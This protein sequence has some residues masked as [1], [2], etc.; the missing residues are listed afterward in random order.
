MKPIRCTEDLE[1]AVLYLASDAEVISHRLAEVDGELAKRLEETAGGLLRRIGRYAGGLRRQILLRPCAEVLDAAGLAGF[2]LRRAQ[3]TVVANAQELRRGYWAAVALDE[4]LAAARRRG[5]DPLQAAL[6]A[7][8]E[9]YGELEGV[10][11][12]IVEHDLDCRQ[13]R[14]ASARLG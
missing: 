12:A 5:L 11:L 9:L 14:T 13:R 7:Q 10:R 2:F 4:A 3:E 6:R 8:E 1:E